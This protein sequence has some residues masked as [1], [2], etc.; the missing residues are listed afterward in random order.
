MPN[1]ATALIFLLAPYGL[2]ASLVSGSLG[3]GAFYAGTIVAA[4]ALRRPLD[5]RKD[6]L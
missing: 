4:F 3:A 2:V 1:T 6:R 5:H